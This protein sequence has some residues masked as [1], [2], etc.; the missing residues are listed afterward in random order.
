LALSNG[1]S[2]VKIGWELASK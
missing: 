2:F 1:I